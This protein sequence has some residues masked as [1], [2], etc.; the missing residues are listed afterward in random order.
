MEAKGKTDVHVTGGRSKS[1]MTNPVD[2]GIDMTKVAFAVCAIVLV[3]IFLQSQS[4][5]SPISPL[6]QPK[7]EKQEF[8]YTEENIQR[9]IDTMVP[10][11][12]IPLG[13]IALTLASLALLVILIFRRRTHVMRERDERLYVIML[14][15]TIAFIVILI[16]KGPLLKWIR[17]WKK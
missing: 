9:I 3:A 13:I 6:N 4:V 8:F 15:V 7:G 14:F 5:E 10:R 11:L 2:Q 16:K 12:I 1:P 17:S